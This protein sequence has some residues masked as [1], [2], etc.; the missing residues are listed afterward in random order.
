MNDLSSVC[1]Y[2]V[3]TEITV[4]GI[5]TGDTHITLGIWLRRFPDAGIPKSL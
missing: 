3:G 2:S 1:K 5:P 4:L